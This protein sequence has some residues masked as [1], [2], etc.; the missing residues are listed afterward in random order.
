MALKK[1]KED[2]QEIVI[3]ESDMEDTH[4]TKEQLEGLL[5]D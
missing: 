2:I 3:Q 5:F 1:V 4:L